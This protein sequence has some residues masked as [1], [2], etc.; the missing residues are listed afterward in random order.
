LLLD[1]SGDKRASIEWAE[2]ELPGMRIQ[3][4]SKAELKWGSKR[5]ALALARRW[6]PEVFALFTGNL[7]AQ[8]ARSS[9]ILFG[10]LA[11]ARLILF[12]D[13]H[14]AI[15]RSRAGAIFLE[16]PRYLLESLVGYLILVPLSWVLTELLMLAL[17][18]REAA[19]ASRS[20]RARG[21]SNQRDAL[22]IKAAPAGHSPDTPAGG[23]ATHVT[24][25]TSGAL[26]LGNR[27]EML[28]SEDSFSVGASHHITVINPSSMLAPTRALFE[29][30]NNL[31]FTTRALRVAREGDLDTEVEFIYQRYNRFN[32]TGVALSLVTGLPLALEFNGSEVWLSQNWDPVGLVWLLRRFE[33][34]N[35]KAADRVF[36]VS[37]VE[38]RRLRSEGIER[39]RIVVNPNGVDIDRFKPDC[40]GPDIRAALGVSDKVVVGFVGTFGPW[41]GAPVLAEAIGRISD[42]ARCHFM[43]IGDGEQRGT[44]ERV[45]DSAHKNAVVTFAGRIPHA[46]VP[47]YLD[48]CD[49]FVAPNVGL[50]D[51]S[52]FFGS[53]TKLFEYMAMAR[54]VVGSRLGQIADVIEDGSNGLLAE[55]G[56]SEALARAIEGLASDAELRTRLGLA[57]RQTVIERYTWKHNAARVFDSMLSRSEE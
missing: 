42:S 31:V 48:A 29:I 5:Q 8:S 27:L 15:R 41:H 34:L 37:E 57:A 32:W 56:N 46:R 26:S 23:M 3:P 6:N 24:G 28:T 2:R 4:I 21:V 19:R 22:Y 50:G 35:L 36:V 51:G 45:I 55:P 14:R 47:S 12:G 52:E 13:E 53:P 11:G 33:R 44:V 10:V 20:N 9:M 16:A 39:V 17:E 49:I 40:G 18:F 7:A 54:P 25:F 30:W 1:L 43:F 38:R